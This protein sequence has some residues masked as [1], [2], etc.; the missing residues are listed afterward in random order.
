M[1]DREEDF[2][3]RWSRRK[4]EARQGLHKK[5]DEPAQP[6]E[7]AP[8]PAEGQAGQPDKAAAQAVDESAFDDVDFDTLDFASDYTR[9][10]Q[11]GVPAAI[12]RRALRQL[13]KSDPVL[14][15]VDGLNDYD[16][17][18]T[19]A[20]TVV[21]D[22]KTAWQVGR[23]YLREDEADETAAPGSDDTAQASQDAEA[24]VRAAEPESDAGEEAQTAAAEAVAD[25][26]EPQ[27]KS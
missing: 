24:A 21:K 1:T 14:A 5:A 12:Q 3:Q 10:M 4:V 11:K 16:L 8:V 6:G 19:D 20:A 25:A 18:Y 9:F 7:S 26:P 27:D 15:C 2:L 23:G 13:W 22:L 17:D